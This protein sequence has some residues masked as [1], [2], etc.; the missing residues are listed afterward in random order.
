MRYLFGTT[1]RCVL[2]LAILVLAL[3]MPGVS[4][5]ADPDARQRGGSGEPVGRAVAADRGS[6]ASRASRL[7]HPRR[8]QRRRRRPAEASPAPRRT[9][10]AATSGA[11]ATPRTT[12]ARPREGRPTSAPRS[13]ADRC[14]GR[15]RT[16]GRS[17][18]RSTTAATGRGALAVS[19]SAAITGA[20]TAAST[21]RFI[22]AMV[23]LRRTAAIL[24]IRISRVRLQLS[25]RRRASAE[26]QAARRPG[27][28]RRLLRRHRRRLRRSVPAAAP[29]AGSASDRSAGAGLRDAHVRRP[30]PVRR[31]DEVRRRTRQTSVTADCRCRFQIDD[32]LLIAR[33]CRL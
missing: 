32:R 22:A 29:R 11:Q 21:I 27:F 18:C 10:P 9:S 20:I 8:R 24:R 13:R 7:P 1:A 15:R 3:A 4:S 33:L 2:L 5:R 23:M 6:C 17:S 28:R 14:R 19:A 12:G 31:H 26:D 25:R 16:T 30:D